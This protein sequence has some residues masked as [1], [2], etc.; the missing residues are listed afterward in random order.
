MYTIHGFVPAWF[1]CT[2]LPYTTLT[3]SDLT[4]LDGSISGLY[5]LYMMYLAIDFVFYVRSTLLYHVLP[6][7]GS[8]MVEKWRMIEA[9]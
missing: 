2:T 1:Y 3:I 7:Q 9:W 6:N 4:I 5:H 8:T